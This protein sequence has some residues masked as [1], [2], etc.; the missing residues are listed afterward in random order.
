[1]SNFYEK[2]KANYFDNYYDPNANDNTAN[3]AD[4]AYDFLYTY[5]DLGDLVVELLSIDPGFE[6]ALVE[7]LGAH[8][9]DQFYK[10]EFK[11]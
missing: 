2:A 8:L 5:K 10:D 6:E 7:V 9:A 4:A 11:Y 3:A 1:M